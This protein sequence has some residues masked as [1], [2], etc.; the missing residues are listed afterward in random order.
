MYTKEKYSL[1]G[2]LYYKFVHILNYHN[3]TQK[4]LLEII[5][6]DETNIKN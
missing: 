3:I 2:W 5:L 4:E 6:S 1:N